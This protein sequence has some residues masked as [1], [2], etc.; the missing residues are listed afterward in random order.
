MKANIR[1]VRK[2]LS[3]LKEEAIEKRYLVY[4]GKATTEKFIFSNPFAFLLGVIA[5]QM[6][7]SERA[8]ML[9]FV[10][11]ARLGYLDLDQFAAMDEKELEGVLRTPT[12]LHRFPRVMARWFI[13]AAKVVQK[14]YHGDVSQLWHNVRSVEELQQRLYAIP[15][16]SQKKSAMMIKML[17]RDWG[18]KLKDCS[19]AE[20]P[21]D[22]HIRRVL[23]RTGLARKD[24]VVAVQEAARVL[25][26][27][28]PA[29]FDDALWLV[30]TRFCHARKPDHK[31]CPLYAVCPKLARQVRL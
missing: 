26:A 2:L 9:P 17:I 24:S 27:H 29:S 20:M 12:V 16:I 23:L 30:G 21:Y 13:G 25:D 14:H 7:V 15:G 4:G 28:Y 18:V 22:I 3:P 1:R 10:L 6:V 8:W 31:R 19:A 11:H 5:D